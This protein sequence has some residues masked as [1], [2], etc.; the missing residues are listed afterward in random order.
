VRQ[1]YCSVIYNPKP[2]PT[3]YCKAIESLEK[4]LEGRLRLSE[5]RNRELEKVLGD[6]KGKEPLN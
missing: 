1:S 6:V 3:R 2:D 5:E 4:E